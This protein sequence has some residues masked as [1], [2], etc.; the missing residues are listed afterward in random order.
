MFHLVYLVTFLKISIEE[1][2]TD[3]FESIKLR[4]L[5]EVIPSFPSPRKYKK[6]PSIMTKQT[7]EQ[8]S[9]ILYQTLG[10]N[11]EIVEQ[12]NKLCSLLQKVKQKKRRIKSTKSS[13]KKAYIQIK[14][15]F[16]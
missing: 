14:K 12:V 8:I 4:L 3:L 16:W 13:I 9:E 2:E 10:D 6:Q 11:G 1:V 7:I 15:S 5:S